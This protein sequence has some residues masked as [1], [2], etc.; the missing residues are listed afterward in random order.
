[1]YNTDGKNNGQK[2]IKNG[3]IYMNLNEII[4]NVKENGFC[5]I[6]NFLEEDDFFRINTF[7][8]KNIFNKKIKKGD[9]KSYFFRD[10]LS[11]F[12]KK[13]IH[14]EIEKIIEFRILN[15]LSKKLNMKSIASEILGKKSKL[16]SIDSYY[17]PTSN[18]PVINW[19]FDQ[20]YSGRKD[21]KNFA[22]PDNRIIKFF[23]YFT[24]VKT[25]DGCLA[26]IPKSNKIAYH[27]KKA[28]YK[29]ELEYKPYWMLRDFRNV[30]KKKEYF[31]YLQKNLGSAFLQSF[32]NDTNFID[33]DPFNTNRFD[34][35]LDKGGAIIFDEGGAHMGSKTKNERLV[36]RFL[37]R[38]YN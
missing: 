21:I 26:Y 3:L 36:L 27:L 24:P 16:Y 2:N 28:F 33:K 10:K 31:L 1:M 13:I 7:L 12:P 4:E 17:S 32:I 6:E 20:A 19:H 9:N 8:K 29:N 11:F 18:K 22:N 30:I 5:K 38:P 35:N 25:D 14:F 15:K 37:Y 23:I 34:L